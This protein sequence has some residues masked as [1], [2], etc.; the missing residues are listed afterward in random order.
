MDPGNQVEELIAAEIAALTGESPEHEPEHARLPGGGVADFR[1]SANALGLIE[2]HVLVEVKSLH[3]LAGRARP[4][5]I[6]HLLNHPDV[7]KQWP[8]RDGWSTAGERRIRELGVSPGDLTSLDALKSLTSLERLRGIADR[9]GQIYGLSV[10]ANQIVTMLLYGS[11]ATLTPGLRWPARA[12]T[13][14]FPGLI[15][16]PLEP[17]AVAFF[18]GDGGRRGV[19]DDIRIGLER[20]FAGYDGPDACLAVVVSDT[21]REYSW[22]ALLDG[23]VGYPVGGG[24][25]VLRVDEAADLPG[26][27]L[28]VHA[29]ESRDQSPWSYRTGETIENT[30]SF[31]A[32]CRAAVSVQREAT[33][34]NGGAESR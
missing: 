29:R 4:W 2:R 32:I 28:A 7:P 30:E 11:G 6:D 33:S 9:G 24:E 18:S 20:K 34:E 10:D 13:T 1:F 19:G 23:A 12:V 15:T 14:P 8:A 25:P 26:L 3:D 22:A 31:E 17:V 5:M 16:K 27:V 21:D